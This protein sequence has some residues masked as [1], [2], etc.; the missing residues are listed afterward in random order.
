MHCST[1]EAKDLLLW[2][3]S[4]RLYNVC[5][6]HLGPETLLQG[7]PDML[8]AADCLIENCQRWRCV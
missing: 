5:G 7:Q 6:A 2:C 4:S 8:H 3:M 1:G